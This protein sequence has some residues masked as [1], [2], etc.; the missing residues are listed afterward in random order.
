MLHCT[1]FT[2]RQ[3]SIK[4]AL[5]GPNCLTAFF[6]PSADS[7]I[8]LALQTTPCQ[9]LTATIPPDTTN[10]AAAATLATAAPPPIEVTATE[11][12]PP[13]TDQSTAAEEPPPVI[14]VEN[15]PPPPPQNPEAAATV[16]PPL[17]PVI[18]NVGAEDPP[19]APEITP[20]EGADFTNINSTATDR[21]LD[22]VYG[23]HP[24]QNVGTHL[25]GGV[26]NDPSGVIGG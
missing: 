23:G 16:L 8:S 4:T 24:H 3:R 20:D 25:A 11:E 26:A 1:N 22:S 14:V 15:P 5:Y 10:T 13:A 7:R 18:E 12:A 2:G 9:I 21:L 17:V 19:P 6:R